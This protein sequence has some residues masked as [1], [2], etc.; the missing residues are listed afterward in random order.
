M[1]SVL[2]MFHERAIRGHSTSR[3]LIQS[4]RGVLFPALRLGAY[5]PGETPVPIPNTAVKPRRANGSKLLRLA[6][7][8]RRQDTVLEIHSRKET[9]GFLSWALFP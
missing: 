3:R 6:R 7:V 5:G 8:G 4:R 1:F 9:C 2:F